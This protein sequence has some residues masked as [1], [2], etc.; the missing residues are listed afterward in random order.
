MYKHF[1]RPLKKFT[2]YLLF[3]VVLLAASC[4]KQQDDTQQEQIDPKQQ[5]EIQAYQNGNEITTINLVEFKSKIDLKTLGT[6]QQAFEKPKFVKEGTML[7]NTAQTYD[8]FALQTD[9]IKVL[10]TASGH[11]SYIFPVK[12]SS[13]RAITFQNL[14]ID[15]SSEGTKIFVNTYTPTK[16]W[17]ADWKAGKAGKFDGDIEVVYLNNTNTLPKSNTANQTTTPSNGLMTINN[18]GCATT[19]YY[20]DLPYNCASGLHGPNDPG[21]Y[22]TGSDRAGVAHISYDITTC[23]EPGGGGGGGGTSPTAPGGYDPCSGGTP[24][25]TENNNRRI[26]GAGAQIMI[27]PPP[28]PE[29]DPQPPVLPVDT[30]MNAKFVKNLKAMCA[31]NK[32]M[33]DGFFKNILNNFIGTNKPIDLTFKLDSI[34]QTPGFQTDANTIPNPATWNSNNIDITLAENVINNLTSLEVGL[35]LLHE[36]VHAEIF[37]KLISIQGP[38]NLSTNNFP[39]LFNLYTQY[40]VNQGYTHEYM[41]NHYVDLIA[42]ALGKFDSNKFTIDYYKAIAWSGLK[43]TTAYNNLSATKKSEITT[44][45]DAL[46]LN[47]SKTNCNDSL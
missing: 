9:S 41:A 3:T 10:T 13:L 20:F 6:L 46:L 11:T 26:M 39:T 14:T 42:S 17:I 15:Q 25:P 18:D 2:N 29:C 35:A 24:Q 40:K 16:K 30:A 32:L 4:K 22:L 23:T 19:T 44:K 8:G 36:G 1:T 21:C 31:L 38:S 28:P 43:G 37:R 34:P 47:R 45:E 33:K 7:L 5:K 27:L 12:P